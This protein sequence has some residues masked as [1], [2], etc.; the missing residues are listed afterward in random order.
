[1]ATSEDSFYILR[2]DRDAYNAK[3]EEG[4]GI[5][6][7]EGVEEVFEIV[8]EVS[9]GV[10]LK[11]FLPPDNYRT[12]CQDGQWIGECLLLLCYLVGSESYTPSPLKPS[13]NPLIARFQTY[14][15]SVTDLT[16]ESAVFLAIPFLSAL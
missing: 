4:A 16:I 15:F 1:M 7:D 9:E 8:A 6:D 12:Q 11:S 13:S 14:T 5:V 2:F 10:I 3:V